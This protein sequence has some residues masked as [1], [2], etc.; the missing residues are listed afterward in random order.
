M[1]D[2]PHEDEESIVSGGQNE[3]LVMPGY[4]SDIYYDVIIKSK[5]FKGWSAPDVGLGTMRF[6]HPEHELFIVSKGMSGDWMRE[7]WDDF[8]NHIVKLEA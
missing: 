3:R 6:I 7:C 1:T 8:I 4:K 2:G 5:E